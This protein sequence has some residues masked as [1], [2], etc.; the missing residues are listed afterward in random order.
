MHENIKTSH[1]R[2]ERLFLASTQATERTMLFVY[3]KVIYI[4][5]CMDELVEK[6]ILNTKQ[7]PKSHYN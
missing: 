4:L 7:P 6:I 1:V 5:W 3:R 2:H